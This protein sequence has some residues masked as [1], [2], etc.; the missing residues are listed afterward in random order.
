MP[1]KAT[2]IGLGLA[3]AAVVSCSSPV[4]TPSP[5]VK[6]VVAPAASPVLAYTERRLLATDS[7]L[8]PPAYPVRTKSNGSWIT[9][10]AADWTSG[11]YAAAL[12]RTYE[13]THDSAWLK[14]AQTWQAK[15]KSR[16]NR[17]PPTSASRSSTPTASAI[18]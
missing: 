14:R 2:T 8:N 6:L 5:T 15:L 9:V 4:P 7:A 1:I 10:G 3:L 18:S 12:W 16:R 13:R 17:T 11:F